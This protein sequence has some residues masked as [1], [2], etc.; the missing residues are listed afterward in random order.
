M[1]TGVATGWCEY[2]PLPSLVE[3]ARCA[4]GMVVLCCHGVLFML[5]PTSLSKGC[6][7]VF[8]H[9]DLPLLM[10]L[11]ICWPAGLVQGCA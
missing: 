2:Y 4:G 8:C 3:A 1:E 10:A 6:A 7:Y 11:V 5:R 9:V